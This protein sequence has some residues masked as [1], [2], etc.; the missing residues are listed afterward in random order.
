LKQIKIDSFYSV[1]IGSVNAEPLLGSP[2]LRGIHEHTV[3]MEHLFEEALTCYVFD[4]KVA[5][6][7][8]FSR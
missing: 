5:Y 2:A 8:Y 6:F 4:V 7:D 1:K 3:K